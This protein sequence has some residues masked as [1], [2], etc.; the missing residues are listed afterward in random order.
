[1]KDAYVGYA[2]I[3][4]FYSSIVI[5]S[6]FYYFKV[7]DAMQCITQYHIYCELSLT[8]VFMS[9]SSEES[10]LGDQL[11]V[12]TDGRMPCEAMNHKMDSLT[13]ASMTFCM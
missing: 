7:A 4:G 9:R 6:H 1:M 11:V 5:V 13:Y 3:D 10:N 8:L 2:G 12:K